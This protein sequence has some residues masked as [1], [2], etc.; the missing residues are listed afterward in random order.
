MSWV[1]YDMPCGTEVALLRLARDIKRDGYISC[2]PQVNDELLY[3][4]LF[5]KDGKQHFVKYERGGWFEMHETEG[6]HGRE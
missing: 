6:E 5:G 4:S 3:A 1:P 2:T